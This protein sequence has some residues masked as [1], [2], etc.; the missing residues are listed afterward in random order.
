M[1]ISLGVCL[2]MCNFRAIHRNWIT[3]WCALHYILFLKCSIILCSLSR[4]EGSWAFIFHISVYITVIAY[5]GLRPLLKITIHQNAENNKSRSGGPQ[6]QYIY[7][8]HNSCT[9]ILEIIIE[10]NSK[11]ERETEHSCEVVSPTNIREGTL[12]KVTSH[13]H[14][15]LKFINHFFI[16]PLY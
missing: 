13:Q 6:F 8:L 9:L 10:E 14:K 12:L 15:C 1:C 3:N 4:D 5:N 16:K 11:I 7:I 2:C